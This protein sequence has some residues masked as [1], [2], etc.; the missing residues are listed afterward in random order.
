LQS[1]S[2]WLEAGK[3]AWFN[4][5]NKEWIQQQ[6]QAVFLK[7]NFIRPTRNIKCTFF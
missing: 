2:N 5:K 4:F 3:E 7:G 1:K 6:E